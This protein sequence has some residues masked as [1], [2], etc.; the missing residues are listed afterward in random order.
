MSQ[1]TAIDQLN[2]STIGPHQFYALQVTTINFTISINSRDGDEYLKSNSSTQTTVIP[3]PQ[4]LHDDMYNSDGKI[5]IN[6]INCGPQ[7]IILTQENTKHPQSE[8]LLKE[9]ELA[10]M[11]GKQQI[12][13]GGYFQDIIKTIDSAQIVKVDY[14]KSLVQQK[15]SLQNMLSHNMATLHN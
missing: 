5:N 3:L 6:F 2:L 13:S 8:M 12:Y 4:N 9:L 14:L 10:L 15:I 7:N 11:L 1:A